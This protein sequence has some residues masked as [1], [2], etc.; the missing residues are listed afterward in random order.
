[1]TG[2]LSGGAAAPEAPDTEL[3]DLLGHTCLLV[4]RSGSDQ[5]Q[6]L[7]P[8]TPPQ[9][10]T[11]GLVRPPNS[12]CVTYTVERLK[13]EDKPPTWQPSIFTYGRLAGG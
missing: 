6:P 8:E 3:T 12:A 5:V 2:G 9:G 11:S 13:E 4:F 7:M 1:M 10:S